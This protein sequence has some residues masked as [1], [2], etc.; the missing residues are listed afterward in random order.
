MTPEQEADDMAASEIEAITQR[1]LEDKTDSGDIPWLCGKIAALEL[2]IR[3]LRFRNAQL[4]D[5]LQ[6]KE[7]P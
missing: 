1:W 5:L 7:T 6:E 4:R 3:L 2:K